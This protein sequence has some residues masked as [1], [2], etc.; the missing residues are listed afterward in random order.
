M[1]KKKVLRN[2][3]SAE[4]NASSLPISKEVRPILYRE[5]TKGAGKRRHPGQQQQ[6][7][8]RLTTARMCVDHLSRQ[9]HLITL[10]PG[11]VQLGM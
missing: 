5:G 2:F 3:E 1:R 9:T 8:T 10:S 6:R 4:I 7:F 11:R